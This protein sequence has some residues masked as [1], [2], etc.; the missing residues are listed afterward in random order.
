MC[1]TLISSVLLNGGSLN[2]SWKRWFLLLIDILR[3]PDPSVRVCQP[4]LA[5]SVAAIAVSPLKKE[6]EEYCCQEA[7]LCSIFM[8]LF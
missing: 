4:R 8:H 3:R 5:S 6:T 1:P 2:C 7:E